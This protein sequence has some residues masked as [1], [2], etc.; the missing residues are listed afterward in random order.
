[1]ERGGETGT[2]RCWAAGL[3]LARENR[4]VGANCVADGGKGGRDRRCGVV[5]GTATGAGGGGG[6][7]WAIELGLR[8]ED[9]FAVLVGEL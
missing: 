5:M 6:S 4:G 9:G 2:P 8:R 1:M 3:G 7:W